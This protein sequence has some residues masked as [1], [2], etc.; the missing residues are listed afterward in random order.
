MNVGISFTFCS[1]FFILLLTVVYF[2]KPRIKTK[3]NDIYSKI[4]ITSL[5]GTIVGLPCY[6]FM[7]QLELFP[8][9]N[10]FFSRL[11]LVYLITWLMLFSLYILVISFPK[12]NFSKVSKIFYTSYIFLVLI[13][14]LLPLNY[15]NVK[16]VY[17][18]GSAANFVYLVSSIFIIIVLYCLFKNIRQ[19]RQKKYY[20]LIFFILFGTVIMIIQKLNPGLLLLTFGEAFI[21]FLMYFTIENPDVKMINELSKNRELVN[22][23]FEDKSN[24]LFITSNQLKSSLQK[25]EKISRNCIEN[26]D[27]NIEIIRD[28]NNLSNNLLFQVNNV[29][30]ISSL[31]YSNIKVINDKYNINVLLNKIKLIEEKKVKD[32]VKFNLNVNELLPKYLYGDSKLLEQILISLVENSIKYTNEGFIDLNVNS[33]IKYDMARLIFTIEDSGLGMTIDKINEL[34]LV[35]TEL[36]EDELKRL[37]TKNVNINTIKKLVAK[38]GGYFT[39][40][41]EVGKGTE[42]KVVVDQRIELDNNINLKNVSTNQK[43]LLASSNNDLSNQMLKILNKRGYSIDTST[44]SNDI[45]DRVRLND[46]YSYIFIDDAMDKRAIEILKKLKTIPEFNTK[47]VVI[48]DKSLDLVKNDLIKDGFYDCIFKEDI[49]K[50]LERILD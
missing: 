11:Y 42:I 39:I 28:I 38:L 35:D 6:Y 24:F 50:E 1:F 18:Y 31:T 17:S 8:F 49:N 30:D 25:I 27:S 45:L 13:D 14:L 46:N 40:K 48:I 7:K 36:S 32:N 15:N 26:N 33:I 37:D 20:P 23:T 19:I 10:F 16:V 5:I 47:V 22:K 4:I 21:T 3:E 2:S 44:Y 34:L 29:M 41:S 12:I 43:I 9:L